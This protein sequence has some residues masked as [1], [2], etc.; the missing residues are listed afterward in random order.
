[1]PDQPG[2]D[3]DLRVVSCTD[4]PTVGNDGGS[5]LTVGVLLM[6]P[7][8]GIVSSLAAILAVIR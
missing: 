4:S 5:D 3:D 8:V 6:V 2:L 1:M 7:T